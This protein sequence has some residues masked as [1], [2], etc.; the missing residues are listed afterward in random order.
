MH[1]YRTMMAGRTKE[2]NDNRVAGHQQ[3]EMQKWGAI[4]EALTIG[5]RN[6]SPFGMRGNKIG[7]GASIGLTLQHGG[8][9]IRWAGQGHAVIKGAGGRTKNIEEYYNDLNKSWG[10]YTQNMYGLHGDFATAQID[11]AKAYANHTAGGINQAAALEGQANLVTYEGA[12]GA[13]KEVRDASVQAAQLRA[14]AAVM[15]AM[16]HN[17]ARSSE[18]GMALRY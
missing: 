15:S 8:N 4:S 16:G 1:T 5:G 10:T 3:R 11:T 2:N 7:D 6:M 18:Q 12:V 9:F 14:V 13:A 17:I